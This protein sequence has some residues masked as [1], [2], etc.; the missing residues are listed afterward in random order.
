MWWPVSKL[1]Q[2]ELSS[3]TLKAFKKLDKEARLA[4][5]RIAEQL[6]AAGMYAA[7]RALADADL[8]LRVSM[9]AVAEIS[10]LVSQRLLPSATPSS[11]NGADQGSS[12]TPPVILS[13]KEK[14]TLVS[15]GISPSQE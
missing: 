2:V 3:A 4:V 11:T 15:L 6:Q 13:L 1:Y 14:M 7:S 5:I 10:S 9:V 12:S 8:V